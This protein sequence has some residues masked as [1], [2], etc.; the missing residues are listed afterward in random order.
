MKRGLSLGTVQAAAM[1]CAVISDPKN[2]P[3][4]YRV[5]VAAGIGLAV[6]DWQPATPLDVPV[7]VL[8]HGLASNARLWDGVAR[9]LS[10]SGAHAI[11]I[12]QRGH[13]QSDKPDTGY[14]MTT[15]AADLASLLDR[16]ELRHPVVVGQSWGANVVVELAAA[17]SGLTSGV[18]AVDGGFI[19]LST[20]FPSWDE[21]KTALAPPK[22]AGTP[23]TQFESW[24]RDAHPDWP[25]T[26]IIG[27]LANVEVRDDG[28]VA[29]WLSFEHHLAVL[30]GLWQ[31]MPFER[32]PAVAEPI[33]WMPADSGTAN[34]TSDK[35]VAITRAMEVHPR[36]EVEWFSPAD[37]DLHAQFPVRVA[38]SLLQA[39][40]TGVFA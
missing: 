7:F 14:D 37:H 39:V 26:G 9:S 36:S 33:L 20:T 27:T 25:E 6:V 15:V 12:D 19:D 30:H 40:T 8:V 18:V 16:L 1:I 17:H 32:L 35:R 29:P 2:A 21:C 13:G 38:N 24:I 23:F 5:E 34:W 11:A 28:T 4:Q 22:F 31:H 3:E 10:A